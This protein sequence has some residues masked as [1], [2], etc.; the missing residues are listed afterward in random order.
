MAMWPQHP[1]TSSNGMLQQEFCIKLSMASIE[2]RPLSVTL[3]RFDD[4][5]HP[6]IGCSPGFLHLAGLARN[7]VLGRNCRFLNQG[8][9]M[10]LRERVRH[11]VRTGVP[12]LGVVE[13]KR[14]LG[15]GEFESFEN[16][17]HL[18]V[19]VAGNRRYILGMQGNVTGL[20]LNLEDGS[21][22]A[23]RL[24]KMFDYVLSAS[25]DAWI[26]IQ[27][28]AI[29]AAPIYLYIRHDGTFRH[30]G[31][32]EVEIVEGD[33]C[34]GG[35]VLQAPDQYL[36]LA[37]Q[38][39]MPHQP[40]EPLKWRFTLL[41][42]SSTPQL[43]R[44]LPLAPSKGSTYD[45]QEPSVNVVPMPGGYNTQGVSDYSTS[46]PTTSGHSGSDRGGS[47]SNYDT[48]DTKA[49]N[50]CA[51]AD[52]WAS[53]MKTQLQ[54]LDFEDPSAVLIARGITKLGLSSA[55]TLRT[56]FSNY[57]LVKAVHVPYA[58][59]K[60]RGAARNAAADDSS[61]SQRIAGRCFIVMESSEHAVKIL[62]AGAVHDV[63]GVQVTLEPFSIK[64]QKHE[65]D[66][67]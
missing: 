66:N 42:D 21:K 19:I 53:T 47:E 64:D 46:C 43:T 17:L 22:D 38:F 44:Q 25:V 28:G 13:N 10:K 49:S 67:T 15:R 18:V 11:A 12:F 6:L 5:D 27:E 59:K 1:A 34:G 39:P 3:A 57:G 61:R 33:A 50:L 9:P 2:G 62:K 51:D 4:P 23:M 29:H 37:P 36:V 20:N 30:D 26:H 54:A 16:L 65:A 58:F 24:Q 56:H 40:Q 52:S 35:P 55:D 14:H 31:E 41:G 60:R 45:R 48:K 8:G 7:D 32:D 63:Q